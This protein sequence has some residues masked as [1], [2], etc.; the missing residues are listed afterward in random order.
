MRKTLRNQLF[1]FITVVL[2]LL[3]IL[4]NAQGTLD[5]YERADSYRSKLRNLVYASKGK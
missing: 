5:D 1:C 3:P 2:I 4:V